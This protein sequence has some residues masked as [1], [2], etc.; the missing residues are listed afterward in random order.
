[1]LKKIAGF[2]F[3]LIASS[4]VEKA[5]VFSSD[6]EDELSQSRGMPLTSNASYLEEAMALIK[7]KTF[8]LDAVT[9]FAA[10]DLIGAGIRGLTASDHSHCGLRLRDQDGTL[11]SFESTGSAHDILFEHASPQVQIHLWDRVVEDYDGGVRF[12][13][14]TFEEGNEPDT[15]LLTDLVTHL[16]GTPYESRPLELID[17]I[18]GKNTSDNVKSIFCSELIAYLLQKLGYISEKRFANNYVPRN[19]CDKQDLTLKK[20]ATLG[21]EITAKAKKPGLACCNLY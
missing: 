20:G 15:Q 14:F 9:L 3:I 16:L 2:L 7:G 1:M 17:A 11:Y 6:Q 10:R 19:F 13:L 21:D 18:R 5:P 12:R 8:T 4:M